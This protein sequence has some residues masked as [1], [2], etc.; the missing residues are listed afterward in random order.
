MEGSLYE[1]IGERQFDLIASNPPFMLAPVQ[2]YLFRDSS[3]P[4]DSISERILLGAGERL[5]HGG[6]GV[7][8]F[9][10]LHTDPR[11]PAARPK[12]WLKSTGC[13]ALLFHFETLDPVA[14]AVRSL[15]LT[16]GHD[17]K[18]Y[19]RQMDERL[20]Y[21]ER[22]GV[23]GVNEGVIILRRCP[24]RA[25]WVLAQSVKAES[26]GS[27]GEQV[28]RIFQAQD[29]LQQLE[30]MSHLL[31]RSLTIVADHQL[32]VALRAQ[33]GGWRTRYAHLK[34]TKG[35][36]FSTEVDQYVSLIVAKCD[37]KHPLRDLVEEAAGK[38]GVR[39]EELA[40]ECLAVVRNL[41]QS[42]F[43]VMPEKK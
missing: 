40:P 34:Q 26:V 3:L 12:E 11:D 18:E 31:S 28:E 36:E 13:D 22:E 37:G 33:E 35:L 7:V 42:G 32:E 19:A 4:G 30:D 10:W 15:H 23:K 21:Y 39:F 9:N 43:F 2:K 25:N 17:Q 16:E 41:M 24:G 5:R 38:M 20:E 14:Y 6:Y 1:P 8:V 29:Y 27:C